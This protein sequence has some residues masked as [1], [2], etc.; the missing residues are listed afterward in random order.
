MR[1]VLAGKSPV[2]LNHVPAAP[3]LQTP[4]ASD[5]LPQDEDWLAYKKGTIDKTISHPPSPGAVT[6]ESNRCPLP[7]CPQRRSAP[8]KHLLF[9][10]FILT[11]QMV[12]PAVPLLLPL[13]TR[14]RCGRV[15]L[16]Q[17]ALVCRPFSTV[18]GGGG[19]RL[20]GSTGRRA[21]RGI[22]N[23]CCDVRSP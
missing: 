2:L 17:H 4:S 8:D 7:S 6:A 18:V 15:G 13:N 20:Q 1:A 12:T 11:L 23:L 21:P 16:R 14:S 22:R 10:A 5:P 9:S 19:G 3:S